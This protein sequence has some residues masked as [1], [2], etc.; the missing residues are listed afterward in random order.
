M[1]RGPKA[2][3][4]REK[5]EAVVAWMCILP[6]FEFLLVLG[7]GPLS[8]RSH[9]DFYWEASVINDL[10]PVPMGIVVANGVPRNYLPGVW[11]TKSTR[12]GLGEIREWRRRFFGLRQGGEPSG[13]GG[14]RR[15]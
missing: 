8:V 7:Q 3:C 5:I 10:L 13:I 9:P 6:A 1:T 12:Y 14:V 4:L 2:R 15:A 11:V